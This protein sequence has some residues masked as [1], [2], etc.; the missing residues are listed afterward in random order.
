MPGSSGDEAT[1]DLNDLLIYCSRCG[2]CLEKCPVYLETATET[3]SPR[4][5]LA[6]IRALTE[7]ELDPGK[8]YTRHIFDCTGC[9]ACTEVCPCGVK[10]NELILAAKSEISPKPSRLQSFILNKV[11]SSP[12]R[13]RLS[14]SPLLLYQ[15]SGLRKLAKSSGIKRFM[16]QR[17]LSLEN[18]LPRLPAKYLATG[19]GAVIS[20]EGR[21]RY[22]VGYFAG[23]AQNL[24]FTSVAQATIGVLTR[25]S[26]EVV[27][28]RGWNCC[29]MPHI[30]YGETEA[31]KRLARANIDCFEA[32]GVE[33]I[34]T[35]C[36]TCGSTLKS[37]GDLLRDDPEYSSR[38]IAFSS[39]VRDISQFLIDDISL[40]RDFHAIKER[41]TYHDPCHLAR[42]QGIRSQPRVIMSYFL[43][44]NFVE[45]KEPDRCCGGAGTYN[46]TH[47]DMSMSILAHKMSSIEATKADVVVTAC[48]GCQIQIGLGIQKFGVDTRVVHL[49]ELLHQA[50]QAGNKI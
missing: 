23:C 10:T 29:G 5:R 2:F 22:R 12:Q 33:T 6:L 46:I 35:G 50:Y 42:G 17:L 34:I 24:V 43:N 28:P 7:R 41:V 36:A 32:A 3:D 31:A 20:A 13:L 26:C 44:D 38:A 30:G 49:M 48:P 25:N 18:M 47:Y 37:Y 40:N 8:G 9:M 4:G 45:M 39:K 1:M 21:R 11:I 27:I 14:F 19:S 15:N 16:P